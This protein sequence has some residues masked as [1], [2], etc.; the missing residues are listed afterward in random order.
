MKIEHID[1]NKTLDDAKKLLE[2]DKTI[3]PALKSMFGVL[4]LIITLLMNRFNL[5]SKNSSKPPSDDPN[6][7][8][9]KKK[10]PLGTKPGGQVGRIGKNLRPVE[11]PD[12]I[13]V[14]SVDKSTLPKGKYHDAGYSARQVINI[15]ISRHVIEYRAQILEDQKW[16]AICRTVSIQCHAASSIRA[17][18]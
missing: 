9:K 7:E 14:L 12:E 17:G 6:R 4:I 11:N 2:D 13:A 8:K 16:K 15:R 5:N 10:N 18:F 3:S 1:I